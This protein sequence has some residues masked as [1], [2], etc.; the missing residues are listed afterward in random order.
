MARLHIWFVVGALMA[1]AGGLMAYKVSVLDFPMLPDQEQSEYY[2]EG[3]INFTGGRG[4]VSVKAALPGSSDRFVLIETGALATG[5]GVIEQTDAAGNAMLFEKR[6]APGEQAIFY[7]TRGF[8]IDSTNVA[9][10]QDSA[11]EATSPFATDLRRRALRTEPTPFLI[12]LDELIELANSRSADNESF[13]RSL[14]LILADSRDERV[15]T[16]VEDAPLDLREG[17]RMLVTA[18][19][20]ADIPA[21]R[22]TGIIVGGEVRSANPVT[23]AEVYFNDR[24][25]RISPRTG[26]VTEGRLFIPLIHG[27]GPLVTG[28]GTIGEPEIRFSVRNVINNKLE[29]ALWSSRAEAPIISWMSLFSLPLDTQIVF[30]VIFLLPLGALVIAFLRQIVG[31]STFGTFMPVLIALSFREIGLWNGIVLFSGIVAIGLGLRAYFSNLHLLLV[32]RLT[33]VLA[34]VTLLMALIAL[35]ANAA[36]VPIG[37]SIALFPLVILTMTIERMSVMWE[38]VGAREALIRGAGSMA[39]AV[40]AFLIIS[41]KQIEY[42]TF[43]FPEILFFVV[44]LAILLGSYNG[45]KLTEY[46]RF[47]MF[48]NTPE[49]VSQ[50]T[51]PKQ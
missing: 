30:R 42:L 35:V 49:T 12:A 14:A 37:L 51:T 7:R 39:A 33:A 15:E 41:N 31:V 23:F 50:E 8:R 11:P 5:F 34:I 19:N 16:L 9:R 40:V 32:P 28:T 22:V 2:I 6:S 25:Q 18:L 44:G 4:P 27:E 47:N 26:R 45:Y 1:L 10:D 38:E 21:R 43:V 29:Q 48:A 36:N 24:W 3:R 17:E 46:L 13:V 20:A